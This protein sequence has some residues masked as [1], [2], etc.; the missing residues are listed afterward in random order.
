MAVHFY[1]GSPVDQVSV[2]QAPFFEEETRPS[3]YR[4]ADCQPREDRA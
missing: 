1:D 4:S 3:G 2:G